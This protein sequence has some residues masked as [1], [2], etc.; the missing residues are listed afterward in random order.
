MQVNVKFQPLPPDERQR[1]LQKIAALLLGPLNAE[2]EKG[3]DSPGK[4]TQRP[5][6]TTM[7]DG[8]QSES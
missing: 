7:E 2:E 4:D 1:R 6:S 8:E 5:D 3:A